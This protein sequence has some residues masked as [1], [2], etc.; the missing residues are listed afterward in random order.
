MV[1]L[2]AKYCAKSGK[3]GLQDWSITIAMLVGMTC[4]Q[5]F[6]TMLGI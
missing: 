6:T 1:V 2:I 5:V 3:K 4:A